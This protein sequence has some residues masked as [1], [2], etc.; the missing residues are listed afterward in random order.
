VEEA[1]KAKAKF[2][3]LYPLEWP[4][5]QK[6]ETIAREIYG[7][8]AVSYSDR[9][10]SEIAR[11]ERLGF[12]R[13]PICVAKTHLSLSHDPNLKGAPESFVLPVREVRASLGAGFIYPLCGEMQTMPGLPSR[14]AFLHIDLDEDGNVVGLS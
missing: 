8:S 10:Q 3:P 11:Y 7:A 13:L 1:C 6:I 9:A 14:P 4:I 12:G 5:T 2:R